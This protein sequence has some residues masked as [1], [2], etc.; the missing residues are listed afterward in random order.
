VFD[1]EREITE[2]GF[3]P[4]G[5]FRER[6]RPKRIVRNQP[7]D[8]AL[9]T[10]PVSWVETL[11]PALASETLRRCTQHTAAERVRVLLAVRL[12]SAV[13]GATSGSAAND[14]G[15]GRNCSKPKVARTTWRKSGG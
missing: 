10:K 7:I 15:R 13:H 11:H 3:D 8:A 14:A 9:Q 2:H 4:G 6:L 1:G 5:F 12:N